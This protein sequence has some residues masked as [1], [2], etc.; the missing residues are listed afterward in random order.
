MFS[1]VN[2]IYYDRI[3]DECSKKE[4]HKKLLFFRAKYCKLLVNE[5]CKYKVMHKKPIVKIYGQ[6]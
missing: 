3:K 1:N 6:G 5:A 4:V 2:C